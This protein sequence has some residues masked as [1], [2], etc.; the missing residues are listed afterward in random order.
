MMLKLQNWH[1][2]EQIVRNIGEALFLV[3]IYSS[4]NDIEGDDDNDGSSS[5]ST[6]T[7]T[8]TTGKENSSCKPDGITLVHQLKGEEKEE[9]DGSRRRQLMEY[10]SGSHSS[11]TA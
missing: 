3:H 6:T 5:Y 8:M 10:C 1:L 7:T 11:M 9:E 4:S 2:T